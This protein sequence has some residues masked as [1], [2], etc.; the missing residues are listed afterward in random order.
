[1]E[2]ENYN[3]RTMK[4]KTIMMAAMAA[5]VA[6]L[7]I[8]CLPVFDSMEQMRIVNRTID[9][10]LIGSAKY[11]NI[12]SV[13]WLL[14]CWGVKY[15]S[16]WTRTDI[17]GM[18]EVGNNNLIPHDS[19]G[20]YGETTLFG[21]NKDHKGYFFIIKQENAKNYSWKEICRYKLYDTLVVTREMLEPENIVEY[22]GNQNR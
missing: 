2:L 16:T 14:E 13:K 4:K 15:D 21:Q 19:M 9:T 5:C 3:I 22:R 6:T 10:I 11:N 1:M 17:M 18:F 7:L 20:C 8:S 12:D